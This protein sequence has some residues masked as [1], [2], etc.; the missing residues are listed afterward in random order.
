M[1][2]I[3]SQGISHINI[4]TGEDITIANL[5]KLIAEVVGYEGKIVYDKSK[6]DGVNKKLLDVSRLHQ[7]GWEE[8]VA[9]QQGISLAYKWFVNNY[10]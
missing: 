9:L 8:Q 1:L 5:A 4:G 2:K 10:K 7:F 3:F 6:P